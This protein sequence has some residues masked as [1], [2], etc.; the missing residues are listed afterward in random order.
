MRREMNA[1]ELEYLY[2]RIGT[3]IWHLQYVETALAPFI[4]I[5]GIAKELRSYQES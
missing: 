1:G 3:A 5:K 4:L 2:N